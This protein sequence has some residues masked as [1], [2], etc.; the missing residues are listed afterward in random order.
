MK[1]LVLSKKEKIVA[2]VI[3]F[4]SFITLSNYL[5][6]NGFYTSRDNKE[7]FLTPWSNIKQFFEYYLGSSSGGTVF[8]DNSELMVYG[9]LPWLVFFTYL[10]LKKKEQ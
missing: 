10:F 2:I 1:N 5:T 3:L 8:F 6:V 7:C 4:W 9:V